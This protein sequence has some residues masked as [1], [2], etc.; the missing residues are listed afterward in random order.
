MIN[1][2]TASF[3]KYWFVSVGLVTVLAGISLGLI[4]L[5]SAKGVQNEARIVQ[6]Q[7]WRYTLQIV[8][9]KIADVNIDFNFQSAADVEKYTNAMRREN[10]AL[11]NSGIQQVSAVSIVFNRTFTWAEADAF[12]KKY[13]LYAGGYDFRLVD[14]NDSNNRFAYGIGLVRDGKTGDG[15]GDNSQQRFDDYIASTYPDNGVFKGIIGLQVRL[16]S[17]EYKTVVADPN[18]YLVDMPG[19]VVEAKIAKQDKPELKGLQKITDFYLPKNSPQLYRSLED[20]G[21][22]KTS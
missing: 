1:N 5:P 6:E 18:V 17:S 12:V 11:F 14:K 15:F 7:D 4:F 19:V 10:L 21:L 3:K 9:G 16:S 8:D 20:F 22:V 2:I 13:Q